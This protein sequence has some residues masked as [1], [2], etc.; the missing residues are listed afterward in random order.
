MTVGEYW[1]NSHSLN[2]DGLT[3]ALECQVR[4]KKFLILIS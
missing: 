1:I 4:V 2:L 3:M